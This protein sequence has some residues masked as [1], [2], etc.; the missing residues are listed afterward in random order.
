MFL[1][2]PRAAGEQLSQAQARCPLFLNFREVAAQSHAK[3][4]NCVPSRIQ[5]DVE[6][7]AAL[8]AAARRDLQAYFLTHFR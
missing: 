7:C 3:S 2:V 8:V 5:V 1:C 4:F 6:R